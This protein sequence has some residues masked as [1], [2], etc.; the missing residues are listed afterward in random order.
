[1]IHDDWYQ[2][3]FWFRR[4]DRG[5]VCLVYGDDSKN[6][7]PHPWTPLERTL[8][9]FVLITIPIWLMPLLFWYAANDAFW[10]LRQDSTRA[11]QARLEYEEKQLNP[12][13]E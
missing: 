11:R 10:R 9:V 4:P 6:P 12:W 3:W 13:S 8:S 2:M 7:R 1:M 5:R